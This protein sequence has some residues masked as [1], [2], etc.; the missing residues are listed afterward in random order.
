MKKPMAAVREAGPSM[1]DMLFASGSTAV[2]LALM[3]SLAGAVSL[4]LR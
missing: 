2:F 4:Y 3:A 1:L